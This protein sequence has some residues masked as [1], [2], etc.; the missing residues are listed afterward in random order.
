[1]AATARAADLQAARGHPETAPEVYLVH[2]SACEAAGR[3]G[4]A[5][6]ALARAKAEVDAVAGRLSPPL[7]ATYLAS[8]VPAAISRASARLASPDAR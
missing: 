2:A 3:L 8:R 1:V 7:R 5:R 4:E 6:D